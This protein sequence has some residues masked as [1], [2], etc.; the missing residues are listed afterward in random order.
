MAQHVQT[1]HTA[2]MP[3]RTPNRI[4]TLRKNRGWSM[5]ELAARIVPTATA[6]QINKLEKG[7]TRLNFDWMHKLASALECHPAELLPD[8]PIVT[9]SEEKQLL[10]RYRGLSEPDKQTAF[11]FLDAMSSRKD[12]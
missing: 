12:A 6:S 7:Y 10:E 5:E 1:G 3:I 11:R 2:H 9:D 4:E 8:P